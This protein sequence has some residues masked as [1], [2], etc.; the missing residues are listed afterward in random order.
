MPVKRF[1]IYLL[2]VVNVVLLTG[3][4]FSLD[5]PN[6]VYAQ[7]GITPGPFTCVTAKVANQDY[8]LL[9]VLDIP[10]HK[11]YAFYPQ[12]SQSTKLVAAPPRDLT[13]D[14]NRDL[15]GNNP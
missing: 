8:D 11:L 6:R 1:L 3:I 14:F 13:Q 9:Y 12:T 5:T 2:S 7:A 4:W 10:S 15:R